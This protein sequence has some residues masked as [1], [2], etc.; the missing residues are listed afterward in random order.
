MTHRREEGAAR[1]PNAAERAYQAIR[2]RILHGSFIPGAPLREEMLAAEIGVS[3]TP[4]R[5][6]LR[7]LLADGLVETTSAGGG[8]CCGCCRPRSCC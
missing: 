7:R 8:C 5:D 3:R 1:I 4:V 6:A 2:D